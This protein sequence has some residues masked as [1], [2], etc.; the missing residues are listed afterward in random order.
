MSK[1]HNTYN[2]FNNY[3]L[4]I[5]SPYI[6]NTPKITYK[7][8]KTNPLKYTPIIPISPHFINKK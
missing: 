6:A 8:N 4:V 1:L 5:Q 3:V 7:K 2:I